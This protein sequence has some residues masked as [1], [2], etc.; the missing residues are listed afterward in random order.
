MFYNKVPTIKI[1]TGGIL[2]FCPSVSAAGGCS[3]GGG[4]GGSGAPQEL[5]GGTL[6]EPD[7]S[8][9]RHTG[10]LPVTGASGYH[11]YFGIRRGNILKA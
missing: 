4:G 9:T 8:L 2:Q 7:T 3:G 11:V 1:L 5:G 6:R 10:C